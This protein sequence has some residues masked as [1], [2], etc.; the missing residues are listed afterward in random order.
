MA[1]LKITLATEGI[2]LFLE[3]LSSGTVLTRSLI[4]RIS[5]TE[6]YLPMYCHY[7]KGDI[8][9]MQNIIDVEFMSFSETSIFNPLLPKM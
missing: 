7:Y 8:G 2:S 6:F 5:C 1:L 9:Y 4:F 3:V